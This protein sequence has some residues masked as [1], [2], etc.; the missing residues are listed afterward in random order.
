MF[1]FKGLVQSLFL[2][3]EAVTEVRDL[4]SATRMLGELPQSDMLI[5]QA[6]I[7]KAL[8]QLNR[9]AKVSIKERLRTI[10][11]LDEKA[12]NLQDYLVRVHQGEIIDDD[13]PPSQLLLTITAF[14]AEM[15]NA[16]QL[17]L[18]QAMQTP[19]KHG[20]DN[21]PLFILRAMRY[22]FE[23]TKWRFMRYRAIDQH[24]WRRIHRLYRWAEQQGCQTTLICPYPTEPAS[25][26]QGNYLKIMMLA[27][28]CPEKM[29]PKQIQLIAGL[30][31]DWVQDIKLETVIQPQRQLFAINLAEAYPPKRLRRD[32]LGETWRYWDTR[33]LL[34]R[35]Q[36]HVSAMQNSNDK[37]AGLTET[38]LILQHER[39]QALAK[40]WSRETSP[41][42]R[43][44]ER[45]ASQRPVKLLHGLDCILH[46]LSGKAVTSATVSPGTVTDESATGLGIE[47]HGKHGET[48]HPC[49]IIGV[50]PQDSDGKLSIGLVRRLERQSDGELLAGVETLAS[51][52]LAV[53]LSCPEKNQQCRTLFLSSSA[54]QQAGH[55]LFVPY[56]NLARDK[57][58]ILAAQGKAYRIR[59]ADTVE[60]T[61]H[62]AL[63]RFTVLEKVDT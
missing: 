33:A 38:A 54:S 1:D 59:L 5:A 24:T 7:I 10:P 3:Q 56:T 58:Y 50:L 29:P 25:S 19:G 27:L 12:R 57:D 28:S 39:I 20:D 6:E 31:D 35:M 41:P 47:I 21:L 16:Y 37:C 44:H 62:A 23:H 42:T 45:R 34:Q 2:P 26:I 43:K 18:K 40:L 22:Y 14:W 30:L 9:N 8:Q 13:A 60:H 53:D 52:P 49:E 51:T 63:T 46:N 55:Y 36:Q 61:S 32:M 4:K 15:G 11:Y 48:L 17:C